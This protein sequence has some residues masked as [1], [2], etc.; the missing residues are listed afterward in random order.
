MLTINT[1]YKYKKKYKYFFHFKNEVEIWGEFDTGLPPLQPSL[2]L[3]IKM[4]CWMF[5]NLQGRIFQWK[6]RQVYKVKDGFWEGIFSVWCDWF[7]CIAIFS[8][9]N[10]HPCVSK[11]IWIFETEWCEIWTSP[12]DPHSSHIYLEIF[13]YIILKYFIYKCWE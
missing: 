8:S 3:W 7:I 2:P 9:Q 10:I 1:N 5:Y 4:V 12:I 11:I 6:L 13:I